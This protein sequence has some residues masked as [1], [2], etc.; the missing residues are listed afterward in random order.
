MCLRFAEDDKDYA[1]YVASGGDFNEN[2]DD[3]FGG[4]YTTLVLI[5]MYQRYADC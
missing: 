1:D 5:I 2:G 3:A 4:I